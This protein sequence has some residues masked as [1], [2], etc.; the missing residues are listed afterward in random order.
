MTQFK[1]LAQCLA[2]AHQRVDTSERRRRMWSQ[3]SRKL[4][5]PWAQQQRYLNLDLTKNLEQHELF[6]V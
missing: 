1:C 4:T 2:R 6:S 5:S 3:L